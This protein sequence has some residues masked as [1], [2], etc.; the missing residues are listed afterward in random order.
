MADIN[1]LKI[2]NDSFGHDK[3][4]ELLKKAASTINLACRAK[5]VIVRYGGD[6]FVALLP[7]TNH[8][9]ATRIANSIKELSAKEKVA[10]IEL[11]ISYGYDT[12]D[13]M[14]KSIMEVFANAENHMYT[15]KLSERSSMRSKTIDIIMNTLFEK[16]NR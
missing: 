6:E 8:D 15:H 1:G 4:D 7:N 16:S 11:S 2:V 10:N 5:N 9:E 14:N 3:G 13:S 12:K